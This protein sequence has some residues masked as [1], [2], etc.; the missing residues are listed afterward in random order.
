MP[1]AYA[2]TAT[3]AA[4]PLFAYWVG[5]ID[6]YAAENAAQALA[7]A[8][9]SDDWSDYTLDDVVEVTAAEL[10]KPTVD[11][12]GA[13]SCTIRESLAAATGPGWLEGFDQ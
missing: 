10:D 5:D 11:E 9:A 2:L 4:A 7:L 3:P 1:H 12:D 6:V 13:P 8:N